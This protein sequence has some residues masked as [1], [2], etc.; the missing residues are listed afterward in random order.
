MS[1]FKWKSD[2]KPKFPN[3]VEKFFGSKITDNTS[4]NESIANVPSVNISDAEKAFEINLVLPGLDKKDLKIEVQNNCLI[5]SSEKQYQKEDRN[6]NWIRKEFGYAS[7]QRMFELPDSADAD[8]IQ[9]NMDKGILSIMVGK[10]DGYMTN[11][12]QI[13]VE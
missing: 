6:K 3:I 2:F 4:V 11:I 10:K 9:A 7:F 12:K 1:L 13:K 8:K 5:I